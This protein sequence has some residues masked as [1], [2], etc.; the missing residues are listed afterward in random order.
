[1]KIRLVPRKY[2]K[3]AY[4]KKNQEGNVELKKDLGIKN[5]DKI[6]KELFQILGETLSFVEDIN[7]MEVDKDEDK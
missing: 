1:M 7:N 4:E 2:I 5:I 6:P 3:K